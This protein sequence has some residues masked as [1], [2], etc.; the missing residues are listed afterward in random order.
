MQNFPTVLWFCAEL[1]DAALEPLP[2]PLWWYS[3]IVDRE[4]SRNLRPEFCLCDVF[5]A[6][7]W[8]TRV[9]S[10]WIILSYVKI[11]KVINMTN[12][13]MIWKIKQNIEIKGTERKVRSYQTCYTWYNL[14]LKG[15]GGTRIWNFDIKPIDGTTILAYFRKVGK[16]QKD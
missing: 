6:L 14:L 15:F 4:P 8:V 2:R 16:F 11:L 7:I 1:C 12:G 5:W 9:C 3:D 10:N 13:R